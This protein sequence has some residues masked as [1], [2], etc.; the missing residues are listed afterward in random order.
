[1]VPAQPLQGPLGATHLQYLSTQEHERQLQANDSQSPVTEETHPDLWAAKTSHDVK[2][3]LWV[4]GLHHLQTVSPTA[5]RKQHP[6]TRPLLPTP[7]PPSV[8]GNETVSRVCPESPLR[9]C[10]TSHKHWSTRLSWTLAYSVVNSGGTV[11]N[12]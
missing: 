6:R 8:S 12:Q 11:L 5:P 1:M 9:M 10:N 4:S 7:R 3:N 2:R